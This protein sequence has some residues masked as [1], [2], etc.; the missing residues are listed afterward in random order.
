MLA[1]FMIKQE[2]MIMAS[3]TVKELLES[4]ATVNKMI[5]QLSMRRK[6]ERKHS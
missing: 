1:K 3:V 6:D 2:F 5:E 4:L